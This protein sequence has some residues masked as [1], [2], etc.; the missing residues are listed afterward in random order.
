M[1]LIYAEK[2]TIVFR[3]MLTVPKRIPFRS[4]SSSHPMLFFYPCL[5][6]VNLCTKRTSNNC[7]DFDHLQLPKSYVFQLQSVI[8]DYFLFLYLHNP[9]LTKT[10]RKMPKPFSILYS[11][12]VFGLL[13]PW[14]LSLRIGKFHKI[15]NVS[16]FLKFMV[17]P[18]YFLPKIQRLTKLQ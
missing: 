16:Y 9:R 2:L 5:Y 6:Y 10:Y 13:C 14:F 1:V 4:A 18:F 17:A 15:L 7:Y 12:N 11:A 3:I 8:V